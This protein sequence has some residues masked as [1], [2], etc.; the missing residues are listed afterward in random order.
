MIAPALD[1]TEPMLK[2][3]GYE[4][5]PM[6][7][8][9]EYLIC[10]GTRISDGLPVF[11][12]TP[13]ADQP[14]PESLARLRSAYGLRD[15]LDAAWATSSLELV[16]H[17]G[18]LI[19]V[20]HDPGGELLESMLGATLA[21]GDV[22]GIARAIASSLGKLHAQGITHRDI[23]PAYIL[24]DAANARAYLAGLGLAFRLPRQRQAPEPP[25]VL[26]GTLA[27]MA[28]E[29]T[30]RMNR[31][32]DSRSDL[33]ALGVT[34]YRMLTGELPFAATDPMELVH[35][36][37][38]R[39]PT[40]PKERRS[41]VPEIVS[42][43]VMKLLAKAPE[44]RYQTADGI[45]H[46]LVRCLEAWSDTGEVSSFELGARDH[47]RRLVLPEK[48]YGRDREIALL[49][50]RFDRALGSGP[51][52]LVMVA[53]YSG[54]GKSSVVSELHK[55]LV[56]TRGLFASG[57]FDQYNRDVPYATFAQ[58][59]GSLVQ[60]LL[61]KSASELGAWRD[62]C[63]RA[64]G[65][66]GALVVRL[67][68]E[69]ERIVGPQPPS[70]ELPPRDAQLI[71]QR[72]MSRMLGVFARPEHPLA[73]FF[74]DLQ[75]MDAA[76][77]EL[78]EVLAADAELGHL[79]LVGAYRDNEV[80]A[81]HPLSRMLGRLRSGSGSLCEIHLGPIS[82]GETGRLVADA[83][84]CD[85]T[86][87]APLA[88]LVFEKAGGNP[89]FT[90]QFISALAEEK[91]LAF[92]PAMAGWSWDLDRIAEKRFTDN[93]VDLMLGKV[94]RLPPASRGLLQRFACIG[95]AASSDV[96]RA[97]A[98]ASEE[99]LHGLL[100]DAV[101]AGLVARAK[102]RYAFVH[103]RVQEAAYA[104]IPE[105]ERGQTHLEIGRLLLARTP[106][107]SL[108]DQVF[109]I[110]DQFNRCREL[111]TSSDERAV[112]A[113]LNLAAG[114]RARGA[115]AFASALAYFAAGE[116][117]LPPDAW[118]TDDALA[119]ALSFGR[120]EC[121]FL[122]GRSPEAEERLIVLSTRTKKLPELAMVAGLRI[123][124][125]LTLIRLE[126]ALEVGLEYLARV[127]IVWVL[128]P[129]QDEV[130]QEFMRTQQLI[131]ERPIESLIDLP[132]MDDPTARG[133]LEVLTEMMTPA[134]F[135]TASLYAV[136][137]ARAVAFSLEHGNSDGSALAYA[138][139]GTLVGSYFGDQD[140]GMRFGQLAVDLVDQ[141]GLVRFRPRVFD[142]VGCLV[143]PWSSGLVKGRSLLRRAL[144]AAQEAGDMPF[145]CFSQLNTLQN[146]IDG[147]EPMPDILPDA[148]EFLRLAARVKF[149]SMI[150][151]M[152]DLI[153]TL[154]VLCDQP[155]DWGPV[156]DP[157]VF[158]RYMEDPFNAVTAC[159]YWIHVVQKRVFDGDAASALQA[160]PKA[161]ALLWTSLSFFH[162]AEFH[163]YTALAHAM[164][165]DEV[166][167]EARAA[168]REGLSTHAAPLAALA[169]RTREAFGPRADI[170]A[171]E[172]ARVEGRAWDALRLYEA[173]IKEA[174]E[175]N[176]LHLE[177]I[178]YERSAEVH[179][180]SGF[181]TT[182]RLYLER[183][184]YCYSRWGAGRKV[185]QLDAKHPS[186]R[187]QAKGALATETIEARL[188]KIDLAT[189][190][191]VSQAVSRELVLGKLVRT[192]MTVVLEHAGACR[193]V[194][195]LP[196][197]DALRFEA[198][199][200]T[201][202]DGVQFEE[203]PSSASAPLA[204]SV[205][206]YVVRARTRVVIANVAAPPAPFADE[207]RF[208][209]ASGSALALPLINQG[210]LS[211]VLYL[212]NDL[213]RD[214]FT[215]ERLDILELLAA[216]AATSLENA[217]L[218][219]DLERARSYMTEAE[220]LGSTGSF[221]WEATSGELAWSD[222]VFRILGH[223]RAT[224][225]PTVAGAE[226]RFHPEDR[227]ALR[228]SV[229]RHVAAGEDFELAGRLR[230]PDGT[231]KH[232]DV[233]AHA[234]TGEGGV[235][236]AYVGAVK[237]VTAR[238]LAD[239][240]RART[241]ATLAH[242]TRVAT[243]GEMTASITH[244]INQ[245]LAA[246]SANAGACMR[247]LSAAVPNLDEAKSAAQRAQR[248][249]KRASEVIA[250]LRG[251]FKKAGGDRKPVDLN[252]AVDELIVLL[253]G[254]LQKNACVV[255]T[256]LASSRPTALGDLVQ[257]QQVLMNL[258][259]NAAEAM[260]EI[261]G[262]P[263]ELVV[264]TDLDSTGHVLVTI[265][266]TGTG[267]PDLELGQIWNPFHTT[268]AGGMGIGLS[269]SRTIVDDHKGRLWATRNEDHGMTFHFTVP[270][271]ES[272]AREA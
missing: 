105:G 55:A 252:A 139:L 128:R 265:R 63:V 38:A 117:W 107:A 28:P 73:L 152:L 36:H 267:I 242:V 204:E 259:L 169:T 144:E 256:E 227:D 83:L 175:Q 238:K 150:V 21:I 137:A 236:L 215:R 189:V 64:L 245:P 104:S 110:V 181:D 91:L 1:F 185:R 136:I 124:L 138:V 121:E 268:K 57:K 214:A 86:R 41:E 211:G 186:L 106:A 266:D 226:E 174:H 12:V 258:M 222:E 208:R 100:D 34:L 32:I 66:H 43:L 173:A 59:L 37:V 111:V 119:F 81:S 8:N 243:L 13:S 56:P 22:L 263:R 213:V 4:L 24:V 9:G 82:P 33:Y 230:M 99:E 18:R 157:D 98:S 29:Q 7:D 126:R 149:D 233:L 161:E 190:L 71:F 247:W 65:N 270:S 196:H 151:P 192:L 11:A 122:T 229:A 116:A 210:R 225:T 68:P 198:E 171:A 23:K 53:G 216:P 200:R 272:A 60:Q 199:A 84:R 133:T 131:G 159:W 148:A 207:P 155:E 201:T 61:V 183:A 170:L 93:V 94:G 179:R 20:I 182:A 62:A 123:P 30:G 10:R 224:T 87:A 221:G 70:P 153:N 206:A 49:S 188:D 195:L 168:H 26:A 79:L 109:E 262:R 257:L 228:A 118:E 255:R 160:V 134:L 164:R 163:F 219:A 89:F 223:D 88:S 154:R 108:G 48:L 90:L 45:E 269:I 172:I 51:P 50:E 40:P 96:L 2:L 5:A 232:V 209:N 103:D 67:V 194:L 147:G 14:A 72:V 31:S 85:A 177:A 6:V 140:R 97:M 114:R 239:E 217:R 46:D 125:N 212:E 42:A 234:V 176:A 74:D 132:P 19:H 235:V 47:A 271:Y 191:K 218:Y 120:A 158:V 240:A 244:E 102:H 143:M 115:T 113:R 231:V 130:A 129:S 142:Y 205:L 187:A 197:G 264:R 127:G 220:R 250:R 95:N 101:R 254:A 76:S 80:D 203:R 260:S 78:L 248:D 249:A 167:E 146:R 141:R 27:Y 261:E 75:W 241:E 25:E 44:D 35:C 165:H 52:E 246:I 162:S 251:M 166:P 180:A 253:R 3:P 202:P 54:I 92:E 156:S 17:R 39:R 15:A 145:T 112:L 135:T 58:A 184:R 77:L 69:L 237:D 16:Q 193:A 178:G